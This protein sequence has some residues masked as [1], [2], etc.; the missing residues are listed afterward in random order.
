[1]RHEERDER[2]IHRLESFSDLVMGFSLALLSL[3]L[4]LPVHIAQLW[5]NPLWLFAYIWTF[6]VIASIWYTHQRLFS[7]YFTVRPYTVFLNFALLFLIGLMVYFVQVFV[8]VAGE[9]DRLWAFLI[10]FCVQGLSFLV[11]GTLYA[12]GVRARWQHLDADLRYTGVRNA[13][14]TLTAGA[15]ILTGVL[16]V[17]LRH[18]Q[19]LD[20]AA[21]VG[22]IAVVGMLGSRL[23]LHVLKDRISGTQT[24]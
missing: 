21:M 2:L 19:K 17:V 14:R 20:D 16:V 18:P 23:V 13:A 9:P 15:A 7:Y 10:Y 8:H 5:Q 22:Y 3:S 6:A 4:A 11:M 12:Q 1:M 24:T